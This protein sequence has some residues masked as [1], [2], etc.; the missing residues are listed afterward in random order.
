[1]SRYFRYAFFIFLAADLA[2]T[3]LD[4]A[5][6]RFVTKPPLVLL[7]MGYFLVSVKENGWQRN[8][9]TGALLLSWMGDCWLLFESRDDL[10]FMLGL[11]SFLL[12]HLFYIVYFHKIRIKE[13]VKPRPWLLIPVVLY[14]GLLIWLLNPYLLELQLPVR[15]YG[16]VISFMLVLALHMFF[17]RPQ[18]AGQWMV[19]GALLFILS[20]SL[21][22]INKFYAPFEK[23]GVLIMLTYGLAQY[24]IAEGAIRYY[25]ASKQAA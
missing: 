5:Q 12:A 15:I 22:A 7:V 4:N 10:F 6:W 21:L 20:D 11:G 23:A 8:L 9:I 3:F 2:V 17:I 14:Y 16:L 19:T 1:M 13:K 25:T 24:C 18:K